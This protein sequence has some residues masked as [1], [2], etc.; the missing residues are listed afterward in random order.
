MCMIGSFQGFPTRIPLLI[1]YCLAGCKISNVLCHYSSVDSHWGLLV[2]H[3]GCSLSTTPKRKWND[4]QSHDC[5][6][7]D[8]TICNQILAHKK[9]KI[10]N[11]RL[12]LHADLLVKTLYYQLFSR[13]I[14]SLGCDGAFAKAPPEDVPLPQCHSMAPST[15]YQP[16]SFPGHIP[17]QEKNQWLWSDQGQTNRPR[18]AHFDTDCAI[19]AEGFDHM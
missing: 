1:E 17:P 7:H 3:K 6:H 5:K 18:G 11:Y 8:A 10:K 12:S 15:S 9:N 14:C 16:V 4:S 2:I 19:V 13:F